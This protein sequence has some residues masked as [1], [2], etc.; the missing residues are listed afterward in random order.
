[1]DYKTYSSRFNQR[2][3][4]AIAV[5]GDSYAR[6][7][8]F[9][10]KVVINETLLCWKSKICI[11][12]WEIDLESLSNINSTKPI[13]NAKA[14]FSNDSMENRLKKDWKTTVFSLIIL[15]RF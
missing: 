2:F 15:E 3:Y 12:I 14:K 8:V 9:N 1:M 6:L 5:C 4:T 11:T 13:S 10:P 7:V